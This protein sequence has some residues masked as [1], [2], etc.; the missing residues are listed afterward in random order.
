MAAPIDEGRWNDWLVALA[1]TVRLDDPVLLDRV[2]E[3][4]RQGHGLHL[5]RDTG[6]EPREFVVEML[7]EAH[8]HG[9]LRRL[10]IDLINAELVEPEFDDRLNPLVGATAFTMQMFTSTGLKPT[11]ALVSARRLLDNCDRVCRIDIEDLH[12]GTGILV[13]PTLVATSAHV[14]ADLVDFRH[15]VLHAR[16]G[17]REKLRLV[18]GYAED[19]LPELGQAPPRGAAGLQP[20]HDD[21]L[22]RIGLENGEPADL[23]PDWLAWGSTRTAQER[24][25]LQDVRDITGITGSDGP[26]DIALIRLAA[27]RRA[28]RW[29][30]LVIQPPAGKFSI[31]VL[32]HPGRAVGAAGEPLLWSIG[33]LDEQLGSPAVRYLHDANTLPG[34]SGAPLFDDEWRVVALHQ[35]GGRTVQDVRHV[36]RLP[37]QARNR[38]VPLCRWMAKLDELDGVV[39]YLPEIR[40]RTGARRR[41]IGRRSTQDRLWRAGR[42]D[43]PAEDRLIIVRGEPGTG[44]RFTKLLVGAYVRRN[45]DGVVAVLDVANALGTD[46]AGFARRITGALSAE[47][48]VVGAATGSTKQ[49]EIRTALAP[50]LAAQLDGLAGSRPVW[51]VLEGFDRAKVSDQHGIDNLLL[52]LIDSLSDYSTIRLVMVAWQQTVHE[53]FARSVDDL[54]PPTAEDVARAFVS[55][56]EEPDTDLLEA[57]GMALR[58]AASAG[59]A[60]YPGA[61]KALGKLDHFFRAMRSRGVA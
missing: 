16:A 30:R 40:G 2:W 44:L 55:P 50:R 54:V 27:P 18:F 51:L 7:W 6:R 13:R 22:G 28:D 1:D 29:T 52:S 46:A 48:A 43:A 24:L 26:W 53:R 61:R 34:S 47:L 8:G 12:R 33:E 31:H 56:G 15:G 41:V 17:S 36:S 42:P 35:G 32:H 38:A 21:G 25:G 10:A 57:A 14:V 9:L 4:L 39:P 37:G 60:G 49:N 19:Y 11:S 3:P 45:G 59:F 23:H 58:D 5:R 20:A